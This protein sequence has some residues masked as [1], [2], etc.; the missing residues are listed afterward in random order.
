[1]PPLNVSLGFC[2]FG[3]LVDGDLDGL[4]TPLFVC[5]IVE[6]YS[7]IQLFILRV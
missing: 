6:I 2:S 1:M 3:C 4:V 7:I 5:K